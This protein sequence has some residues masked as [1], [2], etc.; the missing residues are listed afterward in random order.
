MADATTAPLTSFVWLGKLFEK[1]RHLSK[2][3]DV[4]CEA[5][6][7]DQPV[8]QLASGLITVVEEIVKHVI[9]LRSVEEEY[10]KLENLLQKHEQDIR[11]HIGVQQ[12]LTQIEQQLRL[13]GESLQLQLEESEATRAEFLEKTRI[14]IADVKR[15]NQKLH[16]D[17]MHLKQQLEETR[18]HP[19]A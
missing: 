8:E 9:D 10:V 6:R 17:N 5:L 2:E 7:K 19:R 13:Y 18:L 1:I 4:C 11:K 14:L 16:E 3:C 12:L 15:Q